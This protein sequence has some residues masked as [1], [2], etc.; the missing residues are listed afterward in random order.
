MS[1][2]APHPRP[3]YDPRQ[4]FEVELCDHGP[5]TAW[6]PD[7]H[8]TL[9]PREERIRTMDVIIDGEREIIGGLVLE[10]SDRLVAF[11]ECGMCG[12]WECNLTE[13]WAAKVLRLGPYVFWVRPD[14][15]M[16]TFGA[17]EYA[18]ALGGSVDEIPM[19]DGDDAYDLNEPDREAAY[20]CPDGSVLDQSDENGLLS[21][22][23][24]ASAML[25]SELRAVA[26]PSEAVEVRAMNGVSASIWV[27]AHPRGDGRR[28]AYLP[29]VTWAPVWYAGDAV[30]RVVS[31]LVG[32]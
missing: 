20:A 13:G 6:R 7:E 28:A 10:A 8:G 21:A 26:P 9:T 17:E 29:A 30:D 18:R 27:D 24:L 3:P 25:D 23:S 2:S 31:A 5:C 1:P 19:L 14:G 12:Q 16:F 22:L 15:S 4:R 32:G 11:Y